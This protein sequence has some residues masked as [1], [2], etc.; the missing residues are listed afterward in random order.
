MTDEE[1]I[2]ASA[3]YQESHEDDLTIGETWRN[4]SNW[5][6]FWYLPESYDHVSLDDEEE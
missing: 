6:Y 5:D 2:V 1:R 3:G 4:T